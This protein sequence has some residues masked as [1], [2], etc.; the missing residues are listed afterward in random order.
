MTVGIDNFLG[1]VRELLCVRVR[2]LSAGVGVAFPVELLVGGKL[3]RSRFAGRLVNDE[4]V[5]LSRE[6]AVRVCAAIEMTH[7]ATLLHD[8]V[9]DGGILRRGGPAVWRVT[10]ASGAIL[11]GDLLL[12]DAM[13]L[14]VDVDEGRFLPLFVEK[15]R[16]VCAA[17]AEQELM[18]RGRRPDEQTSLRIA[19][20]K[21]GALFAFV[22]AA[23]GLG[24]D[25]LASALEEA[26]YLFGTAYQLADDILDLSGVEAEAG[27]T[28]G[29]DMARGKFTLPYP[30]ASGV[31]FARNRIPVLC[32]A[33]LRALS[34]WPAVCDGAREFLGC[35]LQRAFRLSAAAD[36]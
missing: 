36:L 35:D 19:R 23:C 15:L 20:G 11:M 21:T 10:G 14:L 12:S 26:G 27:K 3:L 5:P 31:D 24:D 4:S 8:D 18:L 6:T 7:T 29:S 2:R 32:N 17:E 30:G 9:I 33:A 25:E 1:S 28:L 22:G 34:G 16:E 13:G